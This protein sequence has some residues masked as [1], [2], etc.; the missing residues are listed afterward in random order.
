MFNGL[1]TDW[2]AIHA[3]ASRKRL[4]IALLR[5]WVAILALMFRASRITAVY[6]SM[7]AVLACLDWLR[8]YTQIHEQRVYL[9]N[10]V[11]MFFPP[12]QTRFTECTVLFGEEYS[13]SNDS[14][15]ALSEKLLPHPFL[16]GPKHKCKVVL[17][18]PTYL[19]R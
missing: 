1:N 13:P 3:Q 4:A 6:W 16:G 17:G 8:G 19:S 9:M 7:I 12:L 11:S 18:L 10:N 5:S 15:G 2:T 14:E